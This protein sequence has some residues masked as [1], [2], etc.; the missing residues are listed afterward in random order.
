MQTLLLYDITSD[1][2]RLKIAE[3]CMD[4]GLDRTQFSAF[5]GELSR[6]HQQELLLKLTDLLGDEPG[7]LLLIPINAADWERRAEIRNAKPETESVPTPAPPR[8]ARDSS[9]DP[10]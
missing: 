2:I 1:R 5:C 3:T 6:N 8:P 7:A 4:Y 10:F 9:D